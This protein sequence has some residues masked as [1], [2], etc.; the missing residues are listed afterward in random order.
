MARRRLILVFVL[1][2]SLALF[3]SASLMLGGC[4]SRDINS[5]GSPEGT[6]TQPETSSC[7]EYCEQQPHVMCVGRW[8]ISG[9]YPDCRC[10]FICEGEDEAMN[11][12]PF[13]EEPKAGTKNKSEARSPAYLLDVPRA[14]SGASM[15]INKS[16]RIEPEERP[17]LSYLGA[18][19]M[20]AMYD[21]PS[22]DFSD[23]VAY[24]G[25]GTKLANNGY[26]GLNNG[27]KE[28][29]IMTASENLGYDYTL[30]LLSGGAES[31]MPHEYNF[32][33]GS[34][35]KKYFNDQIVA[36][37]YLKR[38]LDS[39]KPVIVH[40]D[41]YYVWDDFA[42]FSTFWKDSWDEGHASHFIVMTGY[43][44]EYVYFNDP[45]DP[46]LSKKNMP[47][48][49]ENFLKA[50]QNGDH[51]SINST[52]V[53]P[54]WMVHITNNGKRKSVRE[55]IE[56]NKKISMD[57]YSAASKAAKYENIGELAVGKREFA[58]FLSKNGYKD[59]AAAYDDIAD[60]YFTEPGL[61]DFK[62]KAYM[63][64]EARD[65][66]ADILGNIQ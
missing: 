64:K 40:I 54:Y 31:T 42:A 59:A 5:E 22:L 33:A 56:W 52:R 17:G 41:T 32:G 16:G 26:T 25:V 50:W 65:R 38:M 6:E 15:T 49:V 4:A 12:T 55:V 37:F 35:E 47:A 30:G 36:Y 19:A 14:Y 46:D 27:I 20:L 58:K 39:K 23:I 28:N 43:D 18:Y 11:I 48:K 7:G 21:D 2:L 34:K 57:A 63:E 9:E 51:P 66:L 61:I 13:A 44:E 8:A 29:S 10:N 3:F 1:A 45:T 62:S 53:G 24:S 60:F